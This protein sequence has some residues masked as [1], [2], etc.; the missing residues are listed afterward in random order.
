[1]GEALSRS[2]EILVAADAGPDAGLGHV[3]RSGA[4]AAS[5]VEGGHRVRCLGLGATVPLARD[6]IEWDPA[7]RPPRWPGVMLLDSYQLDPASIADPVTTLAIVHDG[8]EVPVEVAL[9]ISVN[10]PTAPRPPGVRVL[11]GPEFA[12]LRP[13]FRDVP[14]PTIPDRVERV[15]VTTG[16]GDI[17]APVGTVTAAV[18]ERLSAHL[19]AVVGPYGTDDAVQAHETLTA[20]ESLLPA[21]VE[22]DLVVCAAGQTMLEALACGTPCV[23]IPFVDNQR[24]QAQMLAERRAVVVAESIDH[25]ADLAGELAE[26]AEERRRLSTEGRRTIDGRGAER[27]AAAVAALIPDDGGDPR[28]K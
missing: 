8:D 22:A 25:A 26:D 28:S 4:I 11:A 5:L 9:A 6:G 21:L 13:Q 2:G 24:R 16:G 1:M 3:S 12:S 19:T 23:A 7:E 18:R 14:E 20:P 10:D 15:L 17:A 27:A